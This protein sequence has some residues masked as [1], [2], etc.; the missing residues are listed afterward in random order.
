MSEPPLGQRALD[1]A[2]ALDRA[3]AAAGGLHVAGPRAD[4]STVAAAVRSQGLRALEVQSPHLGFL[5]G[6]DLEFL[7]LNTTNAAIEPEAVWPR[8]A[9]LS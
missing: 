5:A 3:M 4:L 1:G 2:T 9:V 8:F 7:T 6:L